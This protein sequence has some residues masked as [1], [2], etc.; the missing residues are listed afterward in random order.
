ME[1]AEKFDLPI[2]TFVDTAGA[3]PGVGAEQRGQSEAIASSIRTCLNVKVP[4]ISVIIGEGGSG[5]AV[6]LATADKILMLENSI[7]SVISPEGCASILW[8]VEGYDEIAANSL[9]ITSDDL[10]KL[11][12]IDRVVTEPLGG[13][14]R[15]PREVFKSLRIELKKTIEELRKKQRLI[16]LR[17]ENKST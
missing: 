12:V 10:K 7:Y 14:H 1:L 4:I 6:A 13:A 15:N 11:K 8:K 5:G 17:R 3:Y 16:C 2:V 9:K